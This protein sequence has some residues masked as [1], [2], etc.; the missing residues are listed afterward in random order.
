MSTIIKSKLAQLSET[1]AKRIREGFYAAGGPLPSERLLCQEFGLSRVTIR[2]AIERLI[3]EGIVHRVAGKGT[4]LGTDPRGAP[5]QA[6]VRQAKLIALVTRDS[7]GGTLS[8]EQS[9]AGVRA[10][11]EVKGYHLITT[12]CHDDCAA[13]KQIVN[14]LMTE[15]VAGLIISPVLQGDQDNRRFYGML[16]RQRT[17]FVLF[18]RLV[19]GENWS[20]VAI[21]NQRAVVAAVSRLAAEGHRRIA[22]LGPTF[23]PIARQRFRGYLDGLAAVGL[24][25]DESLI[26]H[27]D[28]ATFTPSPAKYGQLGVQHLLDRKAD[29]TAVV[30]F[31]DMVVYGAWRR[32]ASQGWQP[33]V[34]GRSLSGFDDASIMDAEFQ[35]RLITFRRPIRRAAS[36]AAEIL[37]QQIAPAG[38]ATPRTI[39]LEP[40]MII[41]EP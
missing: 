41:P 28:A 5:T 35:R 7:G 33:T 27:G 38:E 18:D 16:T 10:V 6:P 39:V 1:L 20:C 17:P 14:R 34:A 24:P 8:F 29:F 31:S 26:W 15:Q 30:G 37:L 9:T 22:Y 12:G 25:H 21:D 32:L 2:A 40:E 23:Y 13:E 36:M 3:Q 19:A 11:I 4:F